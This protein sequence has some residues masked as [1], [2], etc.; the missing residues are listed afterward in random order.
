MNF[1]EL[2]LCS[3]FFTSISSYINT[4]IMH[5]SSL[6]VFTGGCRQE[7]GEFSQVASPRLGRQGLTSQIWEMTGLSHLNW[8]KHRRSYEHS[9]IFHCQGGLPVFFGHSVSMAP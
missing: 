7:L 1:D 2:G 8:E 3:Y 9:G 6:D 4:Y 5:N